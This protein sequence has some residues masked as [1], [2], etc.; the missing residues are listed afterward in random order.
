LVT[1]YLPDGSATTPTIA[2][3]IRQPDAVAIAE[4]GTI[5]VANTNNRGLDGTGAG[6]VTS[7]TTDGQ[8]PS[9]A[10]RDR[11]APG[12]IAVTH[13]KVYLASSNAYTGTL[14]TYVLDGRR[15]A[16][17]ITTGLYE[18]SAIAIH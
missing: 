14:K 13:G 4:D 8:G 5:Y 16:P 11:E 12:D 1:T 3:R 6:N 18:P 17:T 2:Q 15:I 10:I 7:F 9:H